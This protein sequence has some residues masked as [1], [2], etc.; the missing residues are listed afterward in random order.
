[1]SD[2][3]TTYLVHHG[4]RGQKWG[5]RRYQNEDGSYTPEGKMRRRSDRDGRNSHF[6]MKNSKT[7]AHPKFSNN[8]KFVRGL[9]DKELQRRNKRLELENRYRRNLNEFNYLNDP[10]SN[11]LNTSPRKE[12]L[13]IVAKAAA[14]PVATAATIAAAVAINKMNPDWIKYLAKVK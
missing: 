7:G 1:M 5:D 4:I 9:S 10:V 14:I 2:Y 8:K 6:S 3:H 12:V 13:A 11:A